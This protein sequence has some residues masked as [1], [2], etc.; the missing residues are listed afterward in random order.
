MHLPGRHKTGIHFPDLSSTFHKPHLSFR[1]IDT[2]LSSAH[3]AIY[4][5][6]ESTTSLLYDY[7][8]HQQKAEQYFINK[9]YVSIACTSTLACLQKSQHILM[10]ENKST[11]FVSK[12]LLNKSR[13]PPPVAPLPEHKVIAISLSRHFVCLPFEVN[14][15]AH[16]WLSEKSGNYNRYQVIVF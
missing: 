5:T 12:N 9:Q 2:S 11:I 6:L 3:A 1:K 16:V 8:I 10:A 4:L 15:N 14:R 7:I 13:K